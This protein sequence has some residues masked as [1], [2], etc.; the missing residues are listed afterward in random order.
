MKLVAETLGVARG[1]LIRCLLSMSKSCARY[2]ATG[3]AEFLPLL[4]RLA[5]ERPTYGGRCMKALLHGEIAAT[6]RL[7]ANSKP[8]SLTHSSQETHKPSRG[9]PP[10]PRSCGDAINPQILLLWCGIRLHRR[11]KYQASR[12]RTAP[13]PYRPQL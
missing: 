5:D 4:H 9:P 6:G 7:S 10:L 13:R 2:E 1:I 8:C 3:D 11:Y 12:R